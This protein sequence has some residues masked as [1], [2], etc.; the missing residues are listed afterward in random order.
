MTMSTDDASPGRPT[1][2]RGLTSL[3]LLALLSYA[4]GFGLV[5]L[6][7]VFNKPELEPVAV[8]KTG[9]PCAPAAPAPLTLE[10]AGAGDGSA[11]DEEDTK[12]E[13]SS[14]EKDLEKRIAA[15]EMPAEVPPGRT[16]PN[17]RLDGDALYHKCWTPEGDLVPGERCDRLRVFEKRLENRLY[18]IDRCR[19]EHLGDDAH[20]LLSLGAEIDWSGPAVSFWAGP[21]STLPNIRAIAACLRDELAGIPLREIDHRHGK[22]RLFFS[23]NILDQ[24]KVLHKFAQEDPKIDAGKK[25]Q[26]EVILDR[27]N[28]RQE[29]VDGP[30]IGKINTGNLV[31]LLGRQKDWC[32]VLTPEGN[33]GWMICEALD[34]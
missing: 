8:S 15:A 26:V 30:S 12:T 33:K 4:L 2:R 21:S 22:Y 3:V 28:V 25:K 24:K 17:I 6:F 13:S 19:K 11:D 27:V 14:D 1:G 16:P 18:V 34:L 10:V 20:G 29:P 9:E 23:V 31:M 7:H 32:H 5:L